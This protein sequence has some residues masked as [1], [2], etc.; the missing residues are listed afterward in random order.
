MP[1]V[2]IPAGTLHY[3]TAGPVDSTSPPVVFVHGFL[4]DSRLWDGVAHRLAAAGIRSYLVDWPLGSHRTPMRPDADLTPTGVA[5]MINEVLDALG[6]EHV[7]LVG[8]DTGGAICQLLLAD[9]PQRVGRVVLTNCDAFENFPPKMFVPLFI[10]AR[11]PALTKI[12]LT[13]M[14]LRLL[15]HSPLAF[16]LLLRRPRD[17]E[18]TRH[19]VMPAMTDR[20]IRDDIARFARGL[21]RTSL[22]IAAPRLRDFT[23]R[24]RIVWGTADRCFTLATARRLAAAFANGELVEVPDVSTFV[25]VDAPAAV[26][27]SIIAVSPKVTSAR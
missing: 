4:V 3:R 17:P 1:S 7:T 21:D 15:R 10:A 8:N 22:V 5:R 13:P 11:R 18:L 23:G 25:P 12:L 6:L 2:T 27:G 14:R 24:A 16:G 20:R 19:W 26:A 9:D